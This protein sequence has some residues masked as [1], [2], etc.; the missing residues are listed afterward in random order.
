MLHIEYNP[1]LILRQ[2]IDAYWT[3]TDFKPGEPPFRLLPDGR[4]NIVLTFDRA[5]SSFLS[6]IVGTMTSFVRVARPESVVMFG[7]RFKPAGLTAFTRAPMD[8]FTDS[9]VEL[10]LVETLFG[11]VYKAVSELKT[12]EEIIF[13][14]DNF[15]IAKLADIYDSD[16]RVVHAV[17]L[18]QTANGLVSIPNIADEVCLSSRH[19]E[20]KF[21]ASIGVSPQTFSKITRFQHALQSLQKFPDKDLLTIAVECGFYDH[22]H[23]I[24][25]FKNL[26]GDSPTSFRPQDIKAR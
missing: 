15:F 1:N 4:I 22:A 17:K 5:A 18:I 24:R 25:V 11:D 13:C 16:S 9:S 7:I 14:L 19:F 21:K 2:W 6:E 12:V 10:P 3:E 23:L 8:S 20:R 26:T